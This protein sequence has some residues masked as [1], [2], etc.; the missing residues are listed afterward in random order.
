MALGVDPAQSRTNHPVLFVHGIN[1]G[2]ET[3][4]AEVVDLAEQG[5]ELAMDKVRIDVESKWS[6]HD[7]SGAFEHNHADW[8]LHYS[9]KVNL[10]GRIGRFRV[11]A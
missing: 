8:T 9:A 2:M 4:G 6:D 10:C 7:K 11:C 3:W 1:S 5:C